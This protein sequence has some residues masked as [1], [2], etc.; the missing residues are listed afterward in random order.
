MRLLFVLGCLALACDTPGAG[1]G[2][3]PVVIGDAGT[4]DGS[5]G[6]GAGGGGQGGAGGLGGIAGGGGEDD[7]GGMG[8]AGGGGIDCGADGP[9]VSASLVEDRP[10]HRG[11]AA[12]IDFEVDREAEMSFEADHGG[13]FTP[14]DDRVF[15]AAGGGEPGDVDWP[16]WTGP[17][18]VTIR[19]TDADGCTA[20][21]TV[22]VTLYGDVLLGDLSRSYLF[23]IGSDGR[24][25]G[26]FR[27]VTER[28]IED[29]ILLPDRGFIVILS[30]DGD[31]PAFLRRLD[32]NGDV[33]N[34]FS[35]IGTGGAPLYDH[36]EPKNV[37][38]D[39]VRDLV[40]V[41]N[42][43][44]SHVHRFRLDGTYVD[45]IKIPNNDSAFAD[46]TLGFA[47][48]P[49][50]RVLVGQADRRKLYAIGD[51]GVPQIWTELEAEPIGMETDHEGGVV[52]VMQSGNDV[53]W[54]AF[55]ADGRER[56]RQEYFQSPF[57]NHLIPF[58]DGYLYT[59]NSNGRARYLDRQ[60]REVED[61]AAPYRQMTD[62]DDLRSAQGPIW[63]H[64]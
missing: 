22:H 63:L 38:H 31:E 61:E 56:V 13:R 33:V 60:L 24:R 46:D 21:A 2:N 40:W 15:W 37:I 16:W 57:G 59:T 20:V 53:I 25:L 29:A 4:L 26:R 1:G 9:V 34:D 55:Q 27:Q 3:D 35:T 36:A 18:A 49:D 62:F 17:V 23:A 45:R 6:G 52:V 8:G 43:A 19:A 39:P 47:Q 51:D 5:G 48:L 7:A 12:E 42:G 30:E 41:D 28:G 14:R 50:G 10:Y 32:E 44:D 54:M 58:R 64:R 11:E